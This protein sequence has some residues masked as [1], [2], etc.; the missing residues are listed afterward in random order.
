MECFDWEAWYDRMPGANDDDLHVTGK[1]RLESSSIQVRLEPGNEGIVDEPDLFVLEL[2]VERPPAGDDMVEEREVSW[3]GDAGQGIK[4]V[5]IRG[6]S[7]SDI[8]V[9]EVQ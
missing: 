2:E 3:N 9:R 7:S 1:C 8:P 4:R 5:R 6:G